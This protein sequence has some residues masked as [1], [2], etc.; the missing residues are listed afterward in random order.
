[1][2]NKLVKFLAIGIIA[3]ILISSNALGEDWKGYRANSS[4]SGATSE[5]VPP[6]TASPFLSLKWSTYL[7]GGTITSSPTV[8]CGRLYIG[9]ESGRVY[10]LK[11]E[12]GNPLWNYET[13]SFVRSTPAYAKGRV[14]FGSADGNLY[15][16]D[17][18]SGELIWK[19][20]HGGTQL[21]SPLVVGDRVYISVGDPSTEVR[22]YD[23]KTGELL[24]GTLTGQNSYSSCAY[25][26]GRVII[27]NNS[28]RWLALDAIS[29]AKLWEY[30]TGAGVFLATPAVEGNKVVVAPGDMDRYVY[31]LDAE[32]GGLLQK[33]LPIP[34]AASKTGAT[35]EGKPNIIFPEKMVDSD[36]LNQL[37]NMT[38]AERDAYLDELG[39]INSI[40]YT[41]LKNYLNEQTGDTGGMAKP[42]G[43]GGNRSINLS[44]AIKTSSPTFSG[45][46]IFITQREIS[47]G[48]GSEEVIGYCIDASTGTVLWATASVF[49]NTVNP[50]YVPNPVVSANSYVYI[51]MGSVLYIYTYKNGTLLGSVDVG[52]QITGSPC[53][54]DGNLY[55]ATE[56]GQVLCFE[57]GNLPP[58]APTNFAPSG[59][60]NIANPTPTISWSGAVDPDSSNP[61]TYELVLGIGYENRDLYKL[62]VEAITLNVASYQITAPIP[63]NRHVYYIV[64]SKDGNGAYSGWSGIQD[65]WINR[66]AIP[67]EPPDDLAALPMSGKVELTWSPSPSLD[68]MGYNIYYKKKEEPFTSAKLI[69]VDKDTLSYGVTGLINGQT[70]DF[71]LTAVDY[72]ENES[73]GLIVQASP[74][75]DITINGGG[76]AYATIQDAIDAAKNGDTITIGA[77]T[78]LVSGP[79]SLPQGINIKGHSARYTRIIATGAQVAINVTALIL[80][81]GETA[82]PTTI[83]NLAITGSVTGINANDQDV[84]IRNVLL[85]NLGGDGIIAS[86]NANLR[87]INTTIMNVLGDGI[88][89]LSQQTIVRN[90]IIGKNSG[91]S[92][93]SP[94]EAVITYNDVYE[95]TG[96]ISEPRGFIGL[97]GNILRPAIF[98][99]EANGDYRE[100]SESPTVDAGDPADD[101]TK[102]PEPNGK[103]INMGAYGNTIY[104][105][106]TPAKPEP[107]SEGGGGGG[108]GG[109]YIATAS[110]SNL[111]TIKCLEH[112]RDRYVRTSI[113]G[114]VFLS[115][116][117]TYGPYIAKYVS[118]EEATQKISS[119]L[120]V[121]PLSSFVAIIQTI[122]GQAL[123]GLIILLVA[124]QIVKRT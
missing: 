1:M 68:V 94:E 10:A 96:D 53:L 23:A 73:S 41:P 115:M 26:N 21:S 114:K 15:C 60:Q 27:G 4:R 66:D 35:V 33:I 107:P 80:G 22:A 19:K 42:T 62:D 69:P 39:R 24:W 14:Y 110:G 40:D 108:G 16:I 7:E 29:G 106:T 82:L 63:N 105:A 54:A 11:V 112:F 79:I 87:V 12:D 59:G 117:N 92:I 90:C 76:V 100:K 20:F 78:I 103:R 123:L 31:V 97:N 72:G 93:V 77:G 86:T 102:E 81:E 64:R 67:P 25:Y 17:G 88:E 37:L 118:R 122:F 119:V 91:N 116:Y 124:L 34:P 8:T 57:T 89:S 32:N 47:G 44:K 84:E 5:L 61:L 13:Y 71:M 6:K 43:E 49:L 113:E 48:V 45:G 75:S 3:L 83:S 121:K 74:L 38:K 9:S 104:A 109:C 18:I 51:P 36:T 98:V 58:T 46:K 120:V 101:Y 28:G 95:N 2:N 111:E 50:G 99:D 70:Y 30:A 55:V 52:S 56:G 85:Y 65:F